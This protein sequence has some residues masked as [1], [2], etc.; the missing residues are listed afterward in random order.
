MGFCENV[1]TWYDGC[2]NPED[3]YK[4]VDEVQADGYRFS[5]Y[6]GYDGHRVEHELKLP[7]DASYR[8]VADYFAKFLSD[9]YEYEIDIEA[10]TDM[11]RLYRAAKQQDEQ[12]DGC[13]N[14][15]CLTKK[16]C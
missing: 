4:Y 9:V 13:T 15:S 10:D 11:S 7:F 5:F 16:G 1:D 3:V 8:Q 6:R 12:C 2:D 14:T